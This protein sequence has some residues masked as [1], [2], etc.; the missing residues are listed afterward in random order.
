MTK[1][2]PTTKPVKKKGDTTVIDRVRARAA[3]N[4]AKKRSKSEQKQNAEDASASAS[5]DPSPKPKRLKA[6][7]KKD[8]ASP[9]KDGTSPKKAA[10]SKD[11]AKATKAAPTKDAAASVKKASI[12]EPTTPPKAVPEKETA[13]PVTVNLTDEV[14]YGSDSSSVEAERKKNLGDSGEEKEIISFAEYHKKKVEQT[15]KKL[16]EENAT[17]E[18]SPARNDA[19]DDMVMAEN[20]DLSKEHKR[21]ESPLPSECEASPSQLLPDSQSSDAADEDD[22]PIPM[23]PAAQERLQIIHNGEPDSDEE[24]P[25]VASNQE[26]ARAA[27]VRAPHQTT[28]RDAVAH[29]KVNKKEVA[30][31]WMPPPLPPLREWPTDHSEASLLWKARVSFKDYYGRFATMK[32][33]ADT[34]YPR[35]QAPIPIVLYDGETFEDYEQKFKS[36]L[37][38]GLF[39]DAAKQRAQWSSFAETRMKRSGQT[40]PRRYAS[41]LRASTQ[42]D[43]AR[44]STREAGQARPR[45]DERVAPTSSGSM[46]S[47][48]K[49]P[50][51]REYFGSGDARGAAPQQTVGS[52]HYR[53]EQA[54][55]YAEKSG[56]LPTGSVEE[57]LATLETAYA[58]AQEQIEQL[59][60]CVRANRD[61]DR[62]GYVYL[63][64]RIDRLESPSS[65]SQ[66]LRPRE[67]QPMPSLHDLQSRQV[68]AP[69]VG[70]TYSSTH[71]APAY[72][73]EQGRPREPY[74]G[75]D[76]PEYPPP[77][78][79]R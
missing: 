50:S 28:F 21:L 60:A 71:G 67:R 59:W 31:G 51:T 78:S 63:K 44:D 23:H 42:T 10:P 55:A 34:M 64:S 30:K 1:T 77:R 58:Y 14:D 7:K 57:R 65:T 36:S 73:A 29:T 52:Q 69:P 61:R 6:S 49:T 46:G 40:R 37:K 15:N 8:V 41:P 5:P 62:E 79:Q 38:K 18:A 48:A 39:R 11:A 35:P 19:N 9:E 22:P 2:T 43:H 20:E 70:P 24:K 53:P 75:L 54:V 33:E 17:P 4:A 3:D 12:T 68:I 26:N 25:A 66:R 27:Y 56:Y 45:Q 47:Q 13:A 74:F 32:K 76:E 16:L 72:P